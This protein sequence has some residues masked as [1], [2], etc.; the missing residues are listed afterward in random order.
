MNESKNGFLFPS[1]IGGL[2]GLGITVALLL[3]LPF[4]VLGLDDPNQFVLPSVC[5]CVLIGSAVGGFISASR[6]K[7]NAVVST[8]ISFAAVILPIA[9][10]SLFI[11]GD[12]G[13]AP[14]VG[15]LLSGLAGHG[16]ALLSVMKFSKSKKRKM[17]S[18][19]KRR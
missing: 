15:V 12:M 19:M 2:T 8:L 16:I 4:A 18:V 14:L 17:K 3:V 5:A 1:V 10:I 13:V 6:C 7:E 9:L 11:S